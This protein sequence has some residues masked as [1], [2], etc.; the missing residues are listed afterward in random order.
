MWI[1]VIIGFLSQLID[2]SIGMAY[3]VCAMSMIA[4]AKVPI[5]IASVAVHISEVLTTLISAL[6]H[7][8]M[9][10]VDWYI[11]KRLIPMGVLGGIFG[12]I[13]VSNI[14]YNIFLIPVYLYLITLGVCI[15]FNRNIKSIKRKSIEH[16]RIGRVAFFGGFM[17]A[18]G[19]GWGPIV[20]STM[21]ALDYSPRYVIGSISVAEFVITSVQVI[22]FSSYFGFYDYFK[23]AICLAIGGGIAAPFSAL[24]CRKINENLLRKIVGVVLIILNTLNIIKEIIL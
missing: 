6:S 7:I 12:V 18:M 20:T 2:G 11:L 19:G 15:V 4:F 16:D 9:K 24:L 5:G 17:D 3:G 22:T 13:I 8:K 21:L 10:N 14:K 1:Y 23:I